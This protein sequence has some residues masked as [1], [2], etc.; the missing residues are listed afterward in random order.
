MRA[1]TER[2]AA[3]AALECSRER[4]LRHFIIAMGR[5]KNP[6][7]GKRVGGSAKA[8]PRRRRRGEG[9]ERP[10]R[11]ALGLLATSLGLAGGAASIRSVAR[12]R[13]A[14]PTARR[15]PAPPA[16]H[17]ALWAWQVW[18]RSRQ[19]SDE[20]AVLARMRSRPLRFTEHAACRLDCRRG[21]GTGGAGRRGPGRRGAAPHTHAR[22][23]ARRH[24][25]R[26]EV[27]ESLRSGRVNARKSEP[28]QRPCAKYV[29]DAAVGPRHK[30]VQVG[31]VL[32]GAR[33]GRG[34]AAAAAA[35]AAQHTLIPTGRAHSPPHPPPLLQSVFAACAHETRVVTVID[36]DSD[37]ACGPC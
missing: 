15:S 27:E 4:K 36:R 31:W 19:R 11:S 23:H 26:G 32:C 2:P 1:G 34:A 22:T 6:F 18:Q 10:P 9:A 29:V 37:W 14:Q 16:R 35:A 28:A 21:A 12:C 13:N 7:A 20:R 3:A 33:R 5:P 8:Q 24:I 30:N 17:A 25:T